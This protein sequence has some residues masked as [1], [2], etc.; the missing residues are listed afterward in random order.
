M[1]IRFSTKNT[2]ANFAM[3]WDAANLDWHMVVYAGARHSF[4]N[5]GAD[6][7]GIDALKYDRQADERSWKHMQLFFEEIFQGS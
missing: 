2:F 6:A 4:T 7:H 5:P 3:R 1:P